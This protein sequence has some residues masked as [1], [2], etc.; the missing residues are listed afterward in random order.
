MGWSNDIAIKTS[1]K[2]K[3]N[4]VDELADELDYPYVV[5][6][7]TLFR[8]NGRGELEILDLVEIEDEDT[9]PEYSDYEGTIINRGELDFAGLQRFADHLSSGRIVVKQQS[10]DE[11]AAP[12]LFVVEPGRVAEISINNLMDNLAEHG[13]DGLSRLGTRDKRS[14]PKL[15]HP[16]EPKP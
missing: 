2:I 15:P 7:R 6:G 3:F 14:S 13:L 9:V 11:S 12:T 8:D 4:H 1:G 10:D 5:N 16:S